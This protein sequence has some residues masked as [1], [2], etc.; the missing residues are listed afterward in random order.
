MYYT[1]K[2]KQWTNTHKHTFE[3]VDTDEPRIIIPL[4]ADG[5]V[6]GFQG[7]SLNP[8]SKLR[9]I[10]VMLDDSKPKVFG[11]NRIDTKEVVY[12]TEGPFDSYFLGNAIAMC[13]SDVDLRSMDYQF[14]FVFDNEPRNAEIVKKIDARA[15]AWR[16]GSHLSKRYQGERLE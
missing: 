3:S 1:D 6:F 8:K 5:E 13:G 16:S 12:V 14:V 10:T 11:L 4:I 9:Y 7:R 2:F 15:N